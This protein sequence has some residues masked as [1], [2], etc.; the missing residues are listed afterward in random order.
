MAIVV[1]A[2][3][4]A[5]TVAVASTQMS[6]IHRLTNY[7]DSEHLTFASQRGIDSITRSLIKDREINA[8]DSTA[9]NWSQPGALTAGAAT[10]E[11]ETTDLQAT[12]NLN[13]LVENLGRVGGV[14]GASSGPAQIDV[15]ANSLPVN[16]DNAAES[17]Q[18]AANQKI[19]ARDRVEEARR[20]EK[21]LKWC[22][23]VACKNEKTGSEEVP[24]TISSGEANIAIAENDPNDLTPPIAA[25]RDVAGSISAR[26]ESNISRQELALMRLNK[27]LNELDID[28]SIIQ[29]ILDWTD[30]DSETRYPNGAED[31]YYTTLDNGYRAANRRFTSKRELLLV[32]GITPEIYEKL[33]PNIDILPNDTSINVNTANAKTL[34]SISPMMDKSVANMLI[35]FRDAQPFQTIKSVISHPLMIGRAI[36]PTGLST[37]TEYFN[38]RIKASL[39]NRTVRYA[40]GTLRRSGDDVRLVRLQQG[41]LP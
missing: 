4:T 17:N 7:L 31:E 25:Q 32:R 8:I 10:V 22:G 39:E 18:N 26:G 3:V 13:A 15:A 28:T 41:Y 6:L 33:A 11:T 35:E 38:F 34:S 29:A 40:S 14:I 9:E 5:T 27:L 37:S 2:I 30:A 36:N 12:I 16:P 1:A 20:R 24:Q 21:V 23:T 19:S